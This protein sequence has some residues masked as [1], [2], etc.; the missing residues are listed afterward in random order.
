MERTG[1]KQHDWLE[2][3]PADVERVAG[4]H[5][6]DGCG[7]LR[8]LHVER[9]TGSTPQPYRVSCQC[10][11]PARSI[12]VVRAQIPLALEAFLCAQAS[13]CNSWELRLVAQRQEEAAASV[14]KDR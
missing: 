11:L 10:A 4:A 13:C 8:S 2:A 3:L 6:F 14:S 1:G 9:A 12:R 5:S 7:K